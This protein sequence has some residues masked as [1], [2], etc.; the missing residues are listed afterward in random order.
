MPL[1]F[2]LILA[3]VFGTW[4]RGALP[5]LRAT[6]AR[7]DDF[8][9]AVALVYNDYKPECCYWLVLEKL[10]QMVLVG[11]LQLCWP[12]SLTQVGLALMYAII[13]YSLL[14]RLWPYKS[15]RRNNL[16][17]GTSMSLISLFFCTVF[18]RVA[19]LTEET[20]IQERMSTEQVAAFDVPANMLTIITFACVLGIL[21]LSATVS[22]T[23][24]S[25]ETQLMVNL[26]LAKSARR[27]RYISSDRQVLAPFVE[28]HEFHLFL[29]H[30]WAT[31]Q[32]TLPNIHITYS[33]R[34]AN[35]G[36]I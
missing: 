32:G 23:Q 7:K 29:S 13:H 6:H 33:S 34:L 17:A 9:R 14:L 12:G 15:H 11:I 21:L 20:T 8:S 24:I 3:R 27:L 16:A 26:S 10:Q 31:A 28:L 22:L 5:G 1:G 30:V 4:H 35:Q 36:L 2:L 19:S 18:L 25:E